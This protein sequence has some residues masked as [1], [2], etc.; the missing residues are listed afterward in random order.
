MPLLLKLLQ[1]KLELIFILS[2]FFLLNK[3]VLFLS[4]YLSY[5]T[6]NTATMYI[7]VFKIA[8]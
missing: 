7:Q 6:W 5:L 8:S 1:R 4:K 3:Y 2:S